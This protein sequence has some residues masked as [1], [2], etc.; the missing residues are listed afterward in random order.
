[1]VITTG[2]TSDGLVGDDFGNILGG[3]SYY[4]TIKSNENVGV[5]ENRAAS[6]RMATSRAKTAS[7]IRGSPLGPVVNASDSGVG[8][9]EPTVSESILAGNELGLL[10]GQNIYESGVSTPFNGDETDEVVVPTVEGVEKEASVA[11]TDPKLSGGKPHASEMRRMSTEARAE[12]S[13]PWV[14]CDHEETQK[15][16]DD[17][18]VTTVSEVTTVAAASTYAAATTVA[19]DTTVTAA[20]IV[21]AAS[22]DAAASTNAVASTVAVTTTAAATGKVVPDKKIARR[23]GLGNLMVD[24]EHETKFKIPFVK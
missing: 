8:G 3:N 4:Y 20:T 14:L 6:Q 9:D 13:S 19:A 10:V 21:S 17:N 12:Y 1:M 15:S 16:S 7:W 23:T 11:Q 5:F 2:G 24:S 22:T 18:T